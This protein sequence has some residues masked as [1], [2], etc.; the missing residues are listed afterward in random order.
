MM[1][2]DWIDRQEVFHD[3]DCTMTNYYVDDQRYC[4]INLKSGNYLVQYSQ[5]GIWFEVHSP[6][7]AHNIMKRLLGV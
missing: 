1:N 6:D 3:A 4:I 7:M 5:Q 2:L